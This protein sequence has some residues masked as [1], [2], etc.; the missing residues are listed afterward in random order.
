[1]TVLGISASGRRKGITHEVVQAV[2]E[3][4][5]QP[6][7]CVSL[8]GLRINGC[9]GCT[10]CAADNRC[11]VEDDW[12]AIGEKM[13]ANE[14][15]FQNRHT[16]SAVAPGITARTP[17]APRPPLPRRCWEPRLWLWP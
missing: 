9:Q 1:M 3:A 4:T 5:G 11:R 17:E 14:F 6:Y 13:Q 15:L 7:E 16:T 2:L 10:R 8:A 12:L